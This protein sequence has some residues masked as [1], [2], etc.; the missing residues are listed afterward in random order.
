MCSQ[1]RQLHQATLNG[2]LP[3]RTVEGTSEFTREEFQKPGSRKRNY[4]GSEE[5]WFASKNCKRGRGEKAPRQTSLPPPVLETNTRIS[6]PRRN[7]CRSQYG[8]SWRRKR[9]KEKE[10][11]ALSTH[12]T[13]R[14][15]RI[16]WTTAKQRSTKLEKSL[17]VWHYIFF[18]KK[19]RQF[20]Y[21]LKMVNDWDFIQGQRKMNVEGRFIRAVVRRKMIWL[22]LPK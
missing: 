5:A 17:Q 18:I 20:I 9:L 16:K 3:R 14:C 10:R 6:T 2:I 7:H 22:F 4:E 19:R 21:F 12:S 13:H 1:S 15:T 11:R 8:S